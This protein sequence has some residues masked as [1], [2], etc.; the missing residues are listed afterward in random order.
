MSARWN[1]LNRRVQTIVERLLQ[2]CTNG[3]FGL[4]CR[5]CIWLAGWLAAHALESFQNRDW[6]VR[7]QKVGTDSRDPY[8]TRTC[9]LASAVY[10]CDPETRHPSSSG[11]SSERVVSVAMQPVVMS[12]RVEAPK[13]ADRMRLWRSEFW[14]FSWA[15]HHG[16]HSELG[17]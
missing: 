10:C 8:C 14:D 5:R 6:Q 12:D 15:W 2:G 16:R 13:K 9:S 3:N 17:P 11:K 4:S 1:R 7:R